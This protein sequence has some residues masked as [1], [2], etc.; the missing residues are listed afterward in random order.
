MIIDKLRSA[1][2]QEHQQLD[3]LLFPYIQEIKTHEQYIQLLTLFYGYLKP[4]Y[5]IIDEYQNDELVL[6]YSGREETGTIFDD[7]NALPGFS[8]NILYCKN[9]P[10]I[11]NSAAAFGAYYVMEGSTLGGTIISK[12]IS[13]NLHLENGKALS[14]FAGYGK[15]NYCMWNSFLSSLEQNLSNHS[16]LDLLIESARET[17]TSFK[18]WIINYYGRN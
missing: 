6:D 2:K 9:F 3:H 7:V 17:F 14:F 8:F 13:E 18:N 10:E 1:T 11:R 15:E 12:K 16:H 4:L 5:N